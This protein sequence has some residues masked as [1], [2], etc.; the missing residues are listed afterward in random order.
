MVSACGDKTKNETAD[1]DHADRTKQESPQ[2]NTNPTDLPTAGVKLK[3]DGLNAVYAQ[4]VHLTTALTED[5][6]EAAKIAANAIEAGAGGIS[7]GKTLASAAARIA[8]A[9]AVEAQRQAYGSLS[10][11]M[12]R[13]VKASGL[14]EGEIHVQYCPMAFDNEGATWISSTREIR[15]PY[16]GQAMLSCGETRESVQ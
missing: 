5:D 12:L 4:Y 2:K 10:Q 6:V 9:E 7:G 8:A 1:H 11:D 13:M 15:N 16:M 14:S 3:D